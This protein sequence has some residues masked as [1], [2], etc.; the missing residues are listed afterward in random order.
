MLE[1]SSAGAND[2][3]GEMRVV[4]IKKQVFSDQS[5]QKSAK[6]VVPEPIIL[7]RTYD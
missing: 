3:L 7:L 4:A 2:I 5:M 6:A 1:R